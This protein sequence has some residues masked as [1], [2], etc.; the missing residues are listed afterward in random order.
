MRI[1]V[2]VVV[3]AVGISAGLMVGL[4]FTFS[5]SSSFSAPDSLPPFLSRCL[6]NS[7]SYIQKITYRRERERETEMDLE[8]KITTETERPKRKIE[9]IPLGNLEFNPGVKLESGT[10]LNIFQ[11][12]LKSNVRVPNSRTFCRNPISAYCG[13]MVR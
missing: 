6:G 2:P 5:F 10:P 9:D 11:L 7:F 4:S 12:L 3:A 8:R 13:Q 1:C